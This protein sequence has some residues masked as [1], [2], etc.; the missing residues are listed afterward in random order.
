MVAKGAGRERPAIR[1]DRETPDRIIGLCQF[2][3][4]QRR[5][6][7]RRA[8]LSELRDGERA[9]DRLPARGFASRN[10]S[11]GG[12]EDEPERRPLVG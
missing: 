2:V 10:P 5:S 1:Q 3:G 9:M 7:E 4:M 6:R 12:R 11:E 8:A